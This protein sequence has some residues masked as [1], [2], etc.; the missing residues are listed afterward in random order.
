MDTKSD[1][2]STREGLDPAE[3]SRKV[4]DEQSMNSTYLLGSRSL[5]TVLINCHL[6]RWGVKTWRWL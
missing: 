4:F 6:I 5:L 2:V 1:Y 3:S